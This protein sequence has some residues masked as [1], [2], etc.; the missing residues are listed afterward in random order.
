MRS[1]A[2]VGAFAGGLGLIFGVAVL[3]GAAVPQ[4]HDPAAEPPHDGGHEAAGGGP[5]AA[6]TAPTGLAVAEDGFRLVA[7][8]TTLPAG[9]AV[10][11]SFRVVGADGEA[12]TGF[13][14]E[15]ERRMHLIVVRRDL[16]GYQH[17]H[18]TM[19]ADG[20]WSVRLRL[21]A[22][23]T[24]RA[25]AD[26]SAD[27]DGHTLATDLSVPGPFAPR[28]LPAPATVDRAGGYTADLDAHGVAAGGTA[29]LAYRLRRAGRPLDGVEQY[30]GADGHLV[31]LREGDMAFLHVHPEESAD[32]ATI[33]FGATLPTAGR[34]RLF[35]Q[36][37]HDGTVRTVA[38]TLVVPR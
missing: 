15:H 3:T 4:I 38:H 6:S 8:A 33:R 11:W 9:E 1:A 22:A 36:F 13:D 34:Y 29:E 20:R 25:Y 12:V 32:P 30:L 37:Q 10:T 35:L 7:D 21:G 27:G 31:A 24:Y 16:T 2:R 19:S 17:L 5:Q 14:L 23:G 26:F 18:P 28:P